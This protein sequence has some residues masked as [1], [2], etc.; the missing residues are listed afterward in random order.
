MYLAESQ[1]KVE[2]IQGI[3]VGWKSVQEQGLLNHKLPWFTYRR[4]T[5]LTEHLK[6]PNKK[7]SLITEKVF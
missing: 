2:P 7:R 6:G 4:F 5:H 3:M 1:K